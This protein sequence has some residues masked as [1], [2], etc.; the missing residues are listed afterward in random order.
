MIVAISMVSTPILVGRYYDIYKSYDG[1]FLI[2]STLCFL[3]SLVIL[4]ARNPNTNK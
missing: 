2:V 3:S 4:F 1:A